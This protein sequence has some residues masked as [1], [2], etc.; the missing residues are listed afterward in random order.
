LPPSWFDHD[1]D[2]GGRDLLG[3][4]LV[5]RAG[6]GVMVA[7]VVEAEAYD[8]PRDPSCHVIARLPGAAEALA[9]PP[10]RYYL[11]RAYEHALLNVV[12]LGPGHP[13]TILVR[14]AE[15]VAGLGACGR[16]GPGLGATPTC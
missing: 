16:T 12:C 5:R 14:A 10:G 3:R 2:G 9:G 15:P 7:R 8:C 4:L 13:A 11:H 1:P 6:S